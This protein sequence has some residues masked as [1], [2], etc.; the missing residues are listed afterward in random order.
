MNP[1]VEWLLE[2]NQAGQRD[3]WSRRS[4]LC[5]ADGGSEERRYCGG[6]G[7]ARSSTHH[8]VL[9]QLPQLACSSTGL[10]VLLQLLPEEGGQFG[11][12][13][14]STGGPQNLQNVK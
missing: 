8:H 12:S 1:V 2:K 3:L 7:L 11:D 9:L 13:D 6:A 14:G 4:D 5:R 10:R